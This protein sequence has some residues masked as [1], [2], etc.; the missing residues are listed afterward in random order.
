MHPTAAHNYS[1]KT[2][3]CHGKCLCDVERCINCN[4]GHTADSNVCPFFLARN[5]QA[6]MTE[7]LDQ[8]KKE[9][10]QERAPAA[11]SGPSKGKGKKPAKFDNAMQE[12]PPTAPQ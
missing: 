12:D 1:C 10:A 7:L 2:I 8:R 5:N 4:S 3:G 6:K 9:R 11:T